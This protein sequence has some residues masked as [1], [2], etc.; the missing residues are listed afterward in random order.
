MGAV[1]VEAKA[2]AKDIGAQEFILEGYSLIIYRALF[3]LSAPPSLVDFVI[4]GLQSLSE[5]FRQVSYS[6]ERH[7]RS[8]PYLLAKHVKGIVD[9]ST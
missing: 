4:Q 6:H 8:R 2:F 1:E 3:G 9:F 7:Q 5:E